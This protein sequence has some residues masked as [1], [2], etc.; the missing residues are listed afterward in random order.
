MTPEE[1]PAHPGGIQEIER[2]GENGAES[3]KVMESLGLKNPA[4]GNMELAPT[5]GRARVAE[6]AVCAT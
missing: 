3:A 1:D 5:V 2:T 4:G 6:A